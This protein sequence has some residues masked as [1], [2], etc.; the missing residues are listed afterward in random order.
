MKV[1]REELLKQLEILKAEHGEEAYLQAKQSLINILI[2]QPEGE[3]YLKAAFPD[4]DVEAAKKSAQETASRPFQTE[5]LLG[6]IRTYLP[7][8]KTEGQ[9]QLFMTAFDTFVLTLNSY[10]AGDLETA[11]KAREALNKVLDVA[12]LMP[13]LQNKVQEVPAEQRSEAASNLVNPPRAFH[14]I[15]DQRR[16]L[17]E[18]EG[19]KDRGSLNEWYRTQRSRI[20]RVVTPAYR[21]ELFDAIRAKQDQL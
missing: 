13:E 4:L 6:M 15:E 21:N 10:Y 3:K 16:L 1:S 7:N 14:E 12:E 9:M 11:G 20:D 8:L 17:A 19:L 18:L 2:L 5:D